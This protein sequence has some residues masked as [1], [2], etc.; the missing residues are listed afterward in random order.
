MRKIFLQPF[1]M[2]A[3]FS[4]AFLSGSCSQIR[5]RSMP[6]YQNSFRVDEDLTFLIILENSGLW[7]KR[8]KYPHYGHNLYFYIKGSEDT[9][10]RGVIKSTV[11]TATKEIALKSRCPIKLEFKISPNMMLL[12][13]K[14]YIFKSEYYPKSR[15]K[16]DAKETAFTFKTL[17]LSKNSLKEWKWLDEHELIKDY[18]NEIDFYIEKKSFDAIEEF[19]AIFPESIFIGRVKEIYIKYAIY[20]IGTQV[21]LEENIENAIKFTHDIKNNNSISDYYLKELLKGRELKKN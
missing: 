20:T 16:E 7:K 9:L 13:D 17:G 8:I 15:K 19:I 14:E 3:I 21:A 6:N 12:P 11:A 10:W 2:L 4:I 5:F 1:F 18:F